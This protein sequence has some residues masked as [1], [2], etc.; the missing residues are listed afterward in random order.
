MNLQLRKNM[1]ESSNIQAWQVDT[2]A[3]EFVIYAHFIVKWNTYLYM[4]G[5]YAYFSIIFDKHIWP[6]IIFHQ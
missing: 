5:Y 2:A 4:F 3:L 1:F 6:S